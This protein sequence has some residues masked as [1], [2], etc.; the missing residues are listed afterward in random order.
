MQFRNSLKSL[1]LVLIILIV[2]AQWGFCA[3]VAKIGMVSFQKILD[4][5]EAGKAAKQEL[6]TEGQSMEAELKS[7]SDDINALQQ[8]LE[9][10]TGLMTKEAR[11]EKKWELDRKIDDAKALKKKYDRKIQDLQMQLLSS[12]RTDLVDLIRNYGQKEGYLLIIEDVSV[13]YAP[14]SIDITDTIIEQYNK[15]YSQKGT[16]TQGPKG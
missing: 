10:D 1:I 3:D 2:G 6:T 15:Q 12:I 9:R 8:M 13:V 5:S 7:R 4:N 14:T 11:E 16:R